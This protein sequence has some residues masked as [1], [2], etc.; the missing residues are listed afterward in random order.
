V[1]DAA[2]AALA[3]HLQQLLQVIIWQQ[4][5]LPCSTLLLLLLLL[6]LA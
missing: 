1:S 2:S 4:G 3:A 6:L 5:I